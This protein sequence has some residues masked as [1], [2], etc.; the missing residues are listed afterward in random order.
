MSQPNPSSQSSQTSQSANSAQSEADATQKK[1]ENFP[2]LKHHVIAAVGNFGANFPLKRVAAV[3]AKLGGTY[4]ED[5]SL[6][7]THLICSPDE[8]ADPGKKGT[9]S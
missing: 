1:R 7:P 6:L 9:V 4:V 3:V 2:F 8:F 5:D